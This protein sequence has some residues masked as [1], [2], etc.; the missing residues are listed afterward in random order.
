[1]CDQCDVERHKLAELMLEHPR[2][3][4]VCQSND[5]VGAGTWI[6]DEKR[7]L[8]VGAKNADRI[9]AFC[10]C[11]VHSDNTEENEKAVMQAVVRSIRNGNSREV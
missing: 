9:F 3:C 5:V 10:L 2:P 4:I 6:P 11:D 7:S 1:V 8:A